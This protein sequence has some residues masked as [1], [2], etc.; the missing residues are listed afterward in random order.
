MGDL[1]LAAEPAAVIQ[2]NNEAATVMTDE[3]VVFVV[4]ACRK[5]GQI[6]WSLHPARGGDPFSDGF[7][8]VCFALHAV[9]F[10]IRS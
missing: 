8:S 6:E 10:R 3:K 9:I 7:R 4:F 5:E 2:A 1:I